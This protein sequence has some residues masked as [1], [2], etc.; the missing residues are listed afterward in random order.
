MSSEEHPTIATD[1]TIFFINFWQLSDGFH[2][3][4]A[5]QIVTTV[6]GGDVNFQNANVELDRFPPLVV[7][8]FWLASWNES[9]QNVVK[10]LSTVELSSL[11]TKLTCFAGFY[12]WRNKRTCRHHNKCIIWWVEYLELYS[13]GGTGGENLGERGLEP[14]EIGKCFCN[15][16]VV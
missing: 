5:N 9:H 6:G 4:L 3:K 8:A 10:K 15:T 12:I 16:A 2:F 1:S 11:L 7:L 13:V 14:G